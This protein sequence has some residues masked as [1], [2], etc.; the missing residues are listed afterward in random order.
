MPWSYLAFGI[1]RIGGPARRPLLAIRGEALGRVGRPLEIRE[2]TVDLQADPGGDAELRTVV[3]RGLGRGE[4]GARPL[5]EL[6]DELL[7]RSIE[8]GAGDGAEHEPVLRRLAAIE[9]P[10]PGGQ[11]PPALPT[12]AARGSP[13]RASPR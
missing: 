11:P 6:A 8:L 3:H 1:L 9:P 7:D 13:R 12:P 4:A 5:P 2:E 10:P